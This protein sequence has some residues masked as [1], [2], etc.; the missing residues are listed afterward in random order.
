ML[1]SRQE[2]GGGD[3]DLGV[4]LAPGLQPLAAMF[5]NEDRPALFLQS[6]ASL[7]KCPRMSGGKLSFVRASLK[8]ADCSRT[9][10][11]WAIP[12]VEAYQLWEA[13]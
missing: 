9:R 3:R 7:R 2:Q 4:Y 13:E 8:V 11:L 6:R 5:R 1:V 10:F 12:P